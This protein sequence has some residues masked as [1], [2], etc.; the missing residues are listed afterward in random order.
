M[1]T[2]FYGMTVACAVLFAVMT[3]TGHDSLIRVSDRKAVTFDAMIRDAVRSD[4]IVVGEIHGDPR[5]HAL[6]LEVIRAL[7]ESDTPMIIGMEMFRQSNQKDLDAWTQGTMPVDRFV[8]IYYQNWN[9]HWKFYE[10]IFLYAREHGIPMAGLNIP[11]EVAKAIA[12]RGFSTLSSDERKMLPPGISCTI[13]KSYMEFIRRA[14][15]GHDQGDA[16][17]FQYFCEAQMVWDK[18]MATNLI[19]FMKENPGK[20]A[21][22]LAGVG[23]AWRRGIPEQLSL[24]SGYRTQVILPVLPDQADPKNVSVEDADYLVLP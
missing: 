15:A 6:E 23:H 12:R 18:S 11:D 8:P 22:V 10:D 7:H 2:L 24:L 9:Q 16:K 1:K 21:V 17:T 3:A 14:Y 5:H 13:D 19:A 20:K 4:V